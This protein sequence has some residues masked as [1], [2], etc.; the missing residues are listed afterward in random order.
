[1]KMMVMVMVMMIL[2]MAND[3]GRQSW[4]WQECSPCVVACPSQL[5][6]AILLASHLTYPI[7]LVLSYLA[8][9]T[10]CSVHCTH[11]PICL[12]FNMLASEDFSTQISLQCEVSRLKQAEWCVLLFVLWDNK[13]LHQGCKILLSHTVCNKVHIAPLSNKMCT[14]LTCGRSPVVGCCINADFNMLSFVSHFV[15]KS[16]YIAPMSTRLWGCEQ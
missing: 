5:H 16:V 12:I 7:L 13:G 9:L 6:C 14:S 1:M 11:C 15:Q 10:C 2:T 8:Y 4:R 3:A